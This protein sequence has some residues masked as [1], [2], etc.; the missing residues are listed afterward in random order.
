[1]TLAYT[2]IIIGII[3]LYASLGCM[4]VSSL[5]KSSRW[6]E[7]WI[8]IALGTYAT[9]CFLVFGGVMYHLYSQL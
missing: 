6:G 5:V 4:L 3:T 1:M 9:G 2:I 7:R 8:N